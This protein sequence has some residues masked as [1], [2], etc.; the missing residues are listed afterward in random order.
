MQMT[1][2]QKDIRLPCN[3]RNPPIQILVTTLSPL[4]S[5]SSKSLL[6]LIP[7]G[8]GIPQFH[9]PR[10]LQWILRIASWP[11]IMSRQSH[12]AERS[13]PLRFLVRVRWIPDP[14]A[15]FG[16]WVGGGLGEAEAFD[17]DAVEGSQG[18]KAASGHS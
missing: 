14:V 10:V 9:R 1:P 17:D 16:Q 3:S 13:T 6:L 8:R 15:T 11:G 5:P 2:L 7:L 4:Y 12:Q 18:S